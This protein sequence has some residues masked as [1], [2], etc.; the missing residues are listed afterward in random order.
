MNRVY[1]A[2]CGYL[3]SRLAGRLAAQYQV[4]GISRRGRA[5][6]DWEQLH[7][8][9]DQEP[10]AADFSDA[11]L[12]YLVPPPAAGRQDTRLRRLLAAIPNQALPSRLVLI[13]TT[14]VYGDNHGEW[15]T[16]DTPPAPRADR[17]HRRLDAE[18]AA[19]EWASLRGVPLV[20]LRIP[21]I[22][23][24]GRLPEKSLRDGRPVVAME[25][26]PWVNRIFIDDLVS[27]CER[28]GQEDAP[29][30]IFNISD[31]HPAKMS[32]YFFKVAEILNLPPPEEISLEEAQA[33]LSP[34]MNAYLSE[35]RR[36]DNR[37]ALAAFGVTLQC[38]T[39][40]QGLPRCIV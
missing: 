25:Q 19:T 29:T 40:E 10:V 5:S 7:R 4:I 16:E 31:G 27:F 12:Y 11:L 36:I 15:V 9:L 35:S 23:G 32:E 28:A 34:G 39:L 21:A 8:D 13:S 18:T 20:I 37:K 22:Y 3:G 30:G 38:P 1:I 6:G 2:G 17:A 24:P 33:L 14:G 26:S